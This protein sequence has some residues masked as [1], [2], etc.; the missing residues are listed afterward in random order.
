M[1][2]KKEISWSTRH[3]YVSIIK[4]LFYLPCRF[5]FLHLIFLFGLVDGGCRRDKCFTQ[6]VVDD[7]RAVCVSFAFSTLFRFLLLVFIDS[8]SVSRLVANRY[9][10]DWTYLDRR[11]SLYIGPW[12]E[13]K[14][15]G[16]E[17]KKR[18][19]MKGAS[20]IHPQRRR[21]QRQWEAE[22]RPTMTVSLFYRER[23]VH[24][25]RV[26]QNAQKPLFGFFSPHSIPL[27]L[28]C[29][30]RAA[31]LGDATLSEYI[32]EM[33]GG[34]KGERCGPLQIGLEH[35]TSLCTTFRGW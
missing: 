9:G 32:N 20:V 3:D 27:T 29:I 21:W 15:K 12:V 11:A 30:Y 19:D 18:K 7:E 26:R 22:Q 8:L 31:R 28:S 6:D 23:T 33:A 2:R 24:K 17:N 14:K 13:A 1:E 4:C 35:F 16:E 25:S 34:Q 5:P 10:K